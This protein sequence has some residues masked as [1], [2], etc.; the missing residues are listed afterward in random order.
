GVEGSPRQQEL[1]DAASF[2][3]VEHEDELIAARNQLENPGEVRVADRV[4][5]RQHTTRG[6]LR[7][8]VPRPYPLQRDLGSRRLLSGQPHLTRWSGAQQAL[9]VVA[10]DGEV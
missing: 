5:G 8:G 3:V 4:E 7:V 10:L 9:D 1:P 6:L 2:G